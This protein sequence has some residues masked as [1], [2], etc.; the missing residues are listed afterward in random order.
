MLLIHFFWYIFPSMQICIGIRLHAHIIIRRC[1]REVWFR[2]TLQLNDA[3]WFLIFT[4]IAS[5]GHK[6]TGLT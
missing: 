3:E 2:W 5:G 4:R 6:R 1:M